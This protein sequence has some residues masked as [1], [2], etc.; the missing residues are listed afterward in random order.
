MYKVS[1]HICCDFKFLNLLIGWYKIINETN[2]PRERVAVWCNQETYYTI[3]YLI[4]EKGSTVS[5]NCFINKKQ[6]TE[7][8]SDYAV[9]FIQDLTIYQLG[10]K[11]FFTISLHFFQANVIT[12]S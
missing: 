7:C 4:F 5:E 12:V 2:P 1:L 8:F 3:K 6:L 10:Y 9:V 11:L